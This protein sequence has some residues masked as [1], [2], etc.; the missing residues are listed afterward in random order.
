MSRVAHIAH[1][2]MTRRTPWPSRLWIHHINWRYGAYRYKMFSYSIWSPRRLFSILSMVLRTAVFKQII[3]NSSCW[4]MHILSPRISSGTSSLQQRLSWY[5]SIDRQHLHV[6]QFVFPIR[7][8]LFSSPLS[9]PSLSSSLPL[10]PLDSA[11]IS[12][13]KSYG[14]MLLGSI[15]SVSKSNSESELLLI[16]PS[17]DD[18]S[19]TFLSAD[20][21]NGNSEMRYNSLRQGLFWF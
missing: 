9:F 5:V 13:S 19:V 17:S 12:G 1:E 10:P 4:V 18:L 14:I 21:E 2:G 20:S 8:V 15:T 3:R 7:A 6:H 16:E 11:D